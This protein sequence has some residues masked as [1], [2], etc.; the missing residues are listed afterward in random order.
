MVNSENI[1]ILSG[2]GTKTVLVS[3]T[4]D[5]PA[6]DSIRVKAGTACEWGPH[7][8]LAVK[9]ATVATPSVITGQIAGL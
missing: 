8:A 9:K 4:N 6:I 3:F 5:F 1:T 7:R 2:Q